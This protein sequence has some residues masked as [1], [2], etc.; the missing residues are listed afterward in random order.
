[1]TPTE[2]VL[3]QFDSGQITL[4]TAERCL[5]DLLCAHIITIQDFSRA[6]FSLHTP[7]DTEGVHSLA[8]TQAD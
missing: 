5:A 8:Q 2:Q 1:M 4:P 6:W 7:P 3:R